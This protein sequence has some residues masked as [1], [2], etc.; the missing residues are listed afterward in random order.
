MRPFVLCLG[1]GDVATMYNN[2]FATCGEWRTILDTVAIKSLLPIP[3]FISPS[4][5][6]TLLVI[7]DYF[8][9]LRNLTRDCSQTCNPPPPPLSLSLYLSASL[10]VEINRKWWIFTP[11]T[12]STDVAY[13]NQSTRIVCIALLFCIRS[14]KRSCFFFC[15]FAFAVSVQM[16]REIVSIE[17]WLE[18]RPKNVHKMH[19]AH[20]T[21]PSGRLYVRVLHFHFVWRFLHDVEGKVLSLSSF[22]LRRTRI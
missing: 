9:T 7:D 12:R 17:L 4:C 5:F 20:R 16:P 22:V 8:V 3:L 15:S 19:I 6:S 10:T 21:A 13:T 1:V 11:Y 18:S 14:T 2:L